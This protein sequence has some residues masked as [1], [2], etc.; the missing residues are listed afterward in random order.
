MQS[1]RHPGQTLSSSD[2][3]RDPGCGTHPTSFRSAPSED[4][5]CPHSSSTAQLRGDASA[6]CAVHYLVGNCLNP[7]PGF[8]FIAERRAGSQSACNL[9]RI[10]NQ[11]SLKLGG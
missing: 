8:H 2:G 7:T 6:L 1:A 10:K 11:T 5:S 9:L 3:E 4:A